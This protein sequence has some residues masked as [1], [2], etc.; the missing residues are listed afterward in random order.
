MTSAIETTLLFS[1]LLYLSPCLIIT[2][3]SAE[4]NG[5]AFPLS[6]MTDPRSIVISVP[7]RGHKRALKLEN[8]AQDCYLLRNSMGEDG[9]NRD[10]SGICT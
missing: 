7:G 2:G 9:D 5:R 4:G 1:V 10:I 8:Y 6:K 3:F